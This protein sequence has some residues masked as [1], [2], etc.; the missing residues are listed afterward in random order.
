MSLTR[1]DVKRLACLVSGA[2]MSEIVDLSLNQ[3]LDHDAA[4]R[5]T[6]TAL[7][8]QIHEFRAQIDGNDR[9]KGTP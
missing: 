5:E 9:G 2:A 3:W 6:I 4:Q 8:K 1:E 7:E